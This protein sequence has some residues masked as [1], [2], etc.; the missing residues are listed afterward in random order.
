VSVHPT[1]KRRATLVSGSG[2]FPFLFFRPC[3]FSSL[4]LHSLLLYAGTKAVLYVLLL[5]KLHVV[6]RHSAAGRVTRLKSNWYRFGLVLFVA[7]LGVAVTMIVGRISLIR[8]NDGAC[9]IGLRLY[10]VRFLLSSLFFFVFTDLF[11]VYR[12]SPCLPS[13]PSRI[14]TSP[15]PSS[16]LSGSPTFPRLNDLPEFPPLPLSPPSLLRS[17]TSSS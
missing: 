2:T 5:E 14:S 3:S 9:I 4:P 6:H 7:W 16:S 10:A 1:R 13:T 8:A 11:F 12:L 15:P 17:Q